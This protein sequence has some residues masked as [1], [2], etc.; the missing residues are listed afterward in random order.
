MTDVYSN[1]PALVVCE[2]A[3]V[4]VVAVVTTSF[5]TADGVVTVTTNPS[6][7]CLW[8]V[9]ATSINRKNINIIYNRV[10]IYIPVVVVAAV[11]VVAVVGDATV[12][13]YKYIIT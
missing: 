2:V 9:A 5:I 6:V 8:L 13:K 3:L 4:V 7:D 1:I 11:V 12:Y 10:H